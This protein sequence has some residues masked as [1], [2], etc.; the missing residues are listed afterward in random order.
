M[1]LMKEF[2]KQFKEIFGDKKINFICDKA[3]EN[4]GLITISNPQS[5]SKETKK[6]IEDQML[7]NYIKN[8]REKGGL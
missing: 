6:K 7:R 4:N 3:N 1:N 8:A 5:L 2:R